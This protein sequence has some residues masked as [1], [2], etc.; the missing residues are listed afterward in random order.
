MGLMSPV[1]SAQPQLAAHHAGRDL[2]SGAA[3][4]KRS[5]PQQRHGVADAAVA[6]LGYHP[7]RL[8]DHRRE[9]SLTEQGQRGTAVTGPGAKHSLG[10]GAAARQRPR[11]RPSR[12]VR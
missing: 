11:G 12:P 6:S 2:L 10:Q 3:G 4:G 7:C 8:M 1:A 9:V 5:R